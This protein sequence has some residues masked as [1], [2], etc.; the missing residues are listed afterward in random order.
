MINIKVDLTNINKRLDKMQDYF[1][2][3]KTENG[4]KFVSRFADASVDIFQNNSLLRMESNK[5]PGTKPAKRGKR[6]SISN[7]AKKYT[8]SLFI[9]EKNITNN[10]LIIGIGVNMPFAMLPMEKKYLSRRGEFSAW[11]EKLGIYNFAGELALDLFALR[12]YGSGSRGILPGYLA[13]RLY[14][15]NLHLFSTFGAPFSTDVLRDFI[16]KQNELSNII[17]GGDEN[18]T[19]E[20]E[21]SIKNI[22]MG[23][24]KPD[25]VDA[26]QEAN[27]PRARLRKKGAITPAESPVDEILS[28]KSTT[29]SNVKNFLSGNF[30]NVKTASGRD[31]INWHPGVRPYDWFNDTSYGSSSPKPFDN[32]IKEIE[33]IIIDYHMALLGKI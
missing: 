31:L 22:I 19:E 23:Q 24:V 33:K 9:Y 28:N 17:G 7:A 27:K 14:P 30:Q 4:K 10:G 18:I 1:S 11:L 13:R 32:D 25:E 2:V 26:I 21:D 20:G 3:D 16:E 5:P 6:L 12:H 8:K 29:D 15:N